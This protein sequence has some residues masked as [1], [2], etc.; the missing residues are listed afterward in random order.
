MA[1]GFSVAEDS[2]ALSALIFLLFVPLTSYIS[3]AVWLGEVVRMFRAGS[4]LRG[5]ETDINERAGDR[6]LFWEQWAHPEEKSGKGLVNVENLQFV[7]ILVGYLAVAVA[8][9]IIGTFQAQPLAPGANAWVGPAASGVI[10]VA[11]AVMAGKMF[12][13]AERLR[14]GGKDEVLNDLQRASAQI[15]SAER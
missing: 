12:A 3:L 1:A 13:K 11:A 2:R 5:L 15:R 7:A 14:R 9:I 10:L 8:S 4:Y 6:V